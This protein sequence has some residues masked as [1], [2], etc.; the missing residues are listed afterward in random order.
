MAR[1]RT[2]APLN[3]KEMIVPITSDKGLCGSTNSGII[4]NLKAYLKNK[5]K[6]NMRMFP[7]GDKGTAAAARPFPEMLVGGCTNVTSPL[8]YPTAMALAE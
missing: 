7:I 4:R 2:K 8:N 5:D 3:P 6:A 1:F